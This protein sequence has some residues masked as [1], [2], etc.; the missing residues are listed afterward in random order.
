MSDRFYGSVR[1]HRLALTIEPVVQALMQE[2]EAERAEVIDLDLPCDIWIDDD[3]STSEIIMIGDPSAN[4]GEL[5]RVEEVLMA[6]GVA[7]DAGSEGKYE[8]PPEARWWRPGMK[9]SGYQ[10]TNPDGQ[11]YLTHMELQETL[12]SVSK[13]SDPS[14]VRERMWALIPPTEMKEQP[15][16]NAMYE[17]KKP[18]EITFGSQAE[19]DAWL[20]P[21]QTEV[22]PYG[23][24]SP[25]GVTP[26]KLLCH[27]THIE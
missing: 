10:I 18:V 8:Y 5:K 27:K 14:V 3:P 19:L 12:E 13:E 17:G 21:R 4:M 9:E 25:E 26:I 20:A 22:A 23:V 15:L 1:F 16:T 2:F 6:C 11:P 7:Y 24:V